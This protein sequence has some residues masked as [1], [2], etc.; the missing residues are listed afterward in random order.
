MLASPRSDQD[1][2]LDLVTQLYGEIALKDGLKR[3]RAEAW[4]KFQQLGLPTRQAEVYRYIRLRNLFSR[5]FAIATPE[6]LSLSEISQY[7]YPES[8]QSVIVFINGVFQPDLSNTTALPKKVEITSLEE[9]MYSFST[10]LDNQWAK[11]IKEESDPFAILNAA[12]HPSGVFIYLPPQTVVEA[13]LQILNILT[14]Q[15]E[16]IPG[17]AARASHCR[18]FSRDRSIGNRC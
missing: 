9:A 8:Q 18:T 10:F 13:P 6:T 15:A 1:E 2:F 4:E 16:K 3:V 11:I 12:T 7:I 14:S 17:D 5:N